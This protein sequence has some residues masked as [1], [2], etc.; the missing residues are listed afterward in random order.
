MAPQVPTDLHGAH[1]RRPDLRAV[2]IPRGADGGGSGG[3]VAG[4]TAAADGGGGGGEGQGLVEQLLQVLTIARTR[5][6][7]LT[8]A[9]TLALA[10]A[11]ILTLTLHSGCGARNAGGAFCP[12]CGAPAI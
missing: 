2:R 10:L 7:T 11:P 3:R 9:L 6:L 1:L 4:G 5:T 12:Q 8:L